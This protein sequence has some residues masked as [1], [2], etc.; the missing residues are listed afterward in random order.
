MY[1]NFGIP[2]GGTHVSNISDIGH[3]V[4][5]KIKTE[6]GNIRVAYDIEK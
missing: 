5:R 2:C 1:G 6:K 4:I 3:M